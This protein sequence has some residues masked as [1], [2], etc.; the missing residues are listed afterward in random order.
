MGS[1]FAPARGS[2]KLSRLNMDYLLDTT[3][4]IDVGRDKKEILELVNLLP[5]LVISAVSAGELIQG[6]VDKRELRRAK[7]FLMG[8]RILEINEQISRK[9]REL[10]IKYKLSHGLYLMDAL[11]AATA[12]ENGLMLVTDNLKHFKFIEGIRVV[13]PTEVHV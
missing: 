9:S 12:L 5:E 10:L 4:L 7:I 3:V 2:E 6:V 8:T 13:T 1:R 11:V